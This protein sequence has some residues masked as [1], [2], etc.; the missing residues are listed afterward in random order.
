MPRPKKITKP[1][2]LAELEA[3][4][5]ELQEQLDS[6]KSQRAEIED[7]ELDQMAAIAGRVYVA[8]AREAEEK[9]Q[10]LQTD[11]GNALR[12]K[13]ERALFGLA[14]LPRKPRTRK[15]DLPQNG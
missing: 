7:E 1:Q 3:K 9:W 8:Q 10:Q 6:L 14:P 11:M 4:E 2:T 15:A 12:K 5:R 13:A